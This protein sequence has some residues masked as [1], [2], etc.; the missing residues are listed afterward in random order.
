MSKLT[1]LKTHWTPEDAHSILSL[2]D[3]LRDVLWNT[4]GNDIIECHQKQHL[5]ESAVNDSKQVD[6]F[7]T[8]MDDLIPF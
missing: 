8:G 1:Y 2:L 7:D 4:Y 3:E 5:N 6:P